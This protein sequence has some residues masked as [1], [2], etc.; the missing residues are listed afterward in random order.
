MCQIKA[1]HAKL[2]R[3]VQVRLC[4]A[5]KYVYTPEYILIW[6]ICPVRPFLRLFVCAAD[7]KINVPVGAEPLGLYKAT[8][9]LNAA[10]KAAESAGLQVVNIGAA[11]IIEGRP[12]SILGLSWQLIRVH[13]LAQINLKVRQTDNVG[14]NLL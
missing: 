12:A 1:T 14:R 11:D 7:S 10:L 13:L 5:T 4:T 8:E 2:R 3:A 9:N 6:I